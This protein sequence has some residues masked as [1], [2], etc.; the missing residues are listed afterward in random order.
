LPGAQLPVQ[1]K[2]ARN[3]QSY[4]ELNGRLAV[5]ELADHAAI[6]ADYGGHVVLRQTELP[7]A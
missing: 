6:D 7:S 4:L 1:P 2:R 5:L 3:L